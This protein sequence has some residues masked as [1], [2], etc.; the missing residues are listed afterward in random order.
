MIHANNQILGLWG[1]DHRC[2]IPFTV[3]F[4]SP[5]TMFDTNFHQKQGLS[6]YVWLSTI[7]YFNLGLRFHMP[8]Q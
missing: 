7:V 4:G 6:G 5:A 8:A 2:L 1:L 3:E